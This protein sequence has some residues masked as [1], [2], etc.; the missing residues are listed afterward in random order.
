MTD[1][2]CAL[3]APLLHEVVPESTRHGRNLCLLIGLGF[4][5]S[6]TLALCAQGGGQE[7]ESGIN[8]VFNA[9]RNS[10]PSMLAA[11]A[12]QGM[13][14][15][16]TL[17]TPRLA[18][19]F[20][21]HAWMS[22]MTSPLHTRRSDRTMAVVTKFST[23]D[24][25]VPDVWRAGPAQVHSGQAQVALHLLK[26]DPSL[27]DGSVD[28]ELQKLSEQKEEEQ[29]QKAELEKA[30]IS[31]KDALVL[32]HRMDE[33]RQNER[34]AIVKE[35][36]YLKV[37]R[38]FQQ[39][40]VPML[41]S[42][43]GG[44]DFQFGVIDLK[45]LT[46]DVYTGDAVELVKEHLF[47]LISQNIGPA[48]LMGRVVVLKM[49]L[50]EAGQIYA[51]SCLFGYSLRNADQRLQLE[52]LA[53]NFGTWD[54]PVASEGISHLADDKPIR[55]KNESGTESLK[56]Y[57]STFG[58]EEVQRMLSIST[59][60]AR[61]VMEL[62]IS[63]LFGDLRAMKEQFMNILGQVSSPE[64]AQMRMVQAIENDEVESIKFTSQDLT[65]L[66]LEAVAYGSLLKD[67]EKQVNIVY[68]LTPRPPRPDGSQDGP[69]LPGGD[70]ES[71]PPM[72]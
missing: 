3:V 9:A 34:A 12:W 57:L 31:D 43:Q 54:E 49:P 29:R 27:F 56:K 39:L 36:L 35:L 21:S 68:D 2:S 30:S 32:R 53:G 10:G 44:G 15:A 72:A 50:F 22:D 63:A 52:K 64:E 19:S 24:E 66:V 41:P 18:P 20:S 61:K 37:C 67:A 11:R 23:K 28:S 51:M 8:L 7:Q 46:T 47:R 17:T 70:D 42:L 55:L 1:P 62:Q 45:G 16:R 71:L 26:E 69:F 6:L 13:Q 33:V 40:G 25:A 65:R 58:P 60:E 14:P 38:R 48:P 5:V 4:P 59:M